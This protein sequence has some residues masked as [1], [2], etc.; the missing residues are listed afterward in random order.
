MT[1]EINIR[2]V[3]RHTKRYVREATNGQELIVTKDGK[4]VA[5]FEKFPKMM[6]LIRKSPERNP[7]LS[8]ILSG[9][10]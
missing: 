4:P 7:D 10:F 6:S 2:E 8:G 5:N 1:R 3:L 9:D